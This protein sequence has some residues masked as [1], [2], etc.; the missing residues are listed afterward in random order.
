[1]SVWQEV[2]AMM[3]EEIRVEG[4]INEP[5][6]AVMEKFPLVMVLSDVR[7][8]REGMV[9]MLA[10][11]G[12]VEIIG[13]DDG[14]ARFSGESLSGEAQ[15]TPDVVLLDVGSLNSPDAPSVLASATRMKVIAFGVSGAEH[16]IIAC[17]KAGVCGLIERNGSADDVLMAIEAVRRGEFPCSQ[18]MAGT[19]FQCLAAIVNRHTQRPAVEGFSSR[20]LEVAEYLER[21]WSN[22]KIARQLDISAATVKN[23]VHKLL[24]KLQV[25]RR[26]EVA[27]ALTNRQHRRPARWSDMV[28]LQQR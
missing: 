26:G 16:E 21:G 24:E 5:R 11:T 12:K 3:R 27:G 18:R 14:P 22:K 1:M 19:L 7:L 17:A 28:R 13:I 23:H 20:E 9:A 25:H 10:R 2:C 8:L 15:V 6:V 4:G